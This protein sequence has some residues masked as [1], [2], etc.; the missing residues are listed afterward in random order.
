[1]LLEARYRLSVI[2]IPFRINTGPLPA[3]RLPT[4][5]CTGCT[6]IH[7]HF[8][9]VPPVA[10]RWRQR[11]PES[12]YQVISGMVLRRSDQVASLHVCF[13]FLHRHLALRAP[14]DGENSVSKQDMVYSR[15][16]VR[17]YVRNI[18]KKT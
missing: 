8:S 4:L 6:A 18:D 10:A 5:P 16:Q 9:P 7:P 2:W 1:M 13:S 12:T 17:Q 14:G 3:Q 15:T 11:Q